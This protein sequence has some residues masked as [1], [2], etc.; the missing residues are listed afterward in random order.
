MDIINYLVSLGNITGIL[1]AALSVVFITG[2]VWRVEKKLDVS[3]KLL[4]AAIIFFLFS[5]IISRFIEAN[6]IFEA[7]AVLG[8]VLFSAFFLAGIL[9]MRDLIR[10]VDGEK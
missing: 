4:Q 3:Y 7:L 9:K 1:L 10:T 2:V 8:K 5:E 6:Q